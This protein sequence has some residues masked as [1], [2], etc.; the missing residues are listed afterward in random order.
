MRHCGDV[1]LTAGTG[2]GILLRQALLALCHR[3]HDPRAGCLAPR[4]SSLHVKATRSNCRTSTSLVHVVCG[5]SGL[6]N[7]VRDYGEMDSAAG[8]LGYFEVAS[9]SVCVGNLSITASSA[10]VRQT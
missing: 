3:C 2:H 5:E 8:L 4:T 9:L 7:H 1:R 6:E 10:A